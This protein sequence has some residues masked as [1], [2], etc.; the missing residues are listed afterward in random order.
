MTFSVRLTIVVVA[1]AAVWSASLLVGS[2]ASGGALFTTTTTLCDFRGPD[3]CADWLSVHASTSA[4]AAGGGATT[5]FTLGADDALS[6]ANATDFTATARNQLELEWQSTFAALVVRVRNPRVIRPR[7]ITSFGPFTAEHACLSATSTFPSAV[8]CA[9]SWQTGGLLNPSGSTGVPY[10]GYGLVAHEDDEIVC[11]DAEPG[12]DVAFDLNVVP[13]ASNVT[14]VGQPPSVSESVRFSRNSDLVFRFASGGEVPITLEF[15]VINVVKQRHEQT[16][17]Q[18][19]SVCWRASAL[20]APTKDAATGFRV[21][22][23]VLESTG[24]TGLQRNDGAFRAGFTCPLSSAAAS[25]IG[26]GSSPLD[27]HSAETP[28]GLFTPASGCEALGSSSSVPA[29]YESSRTADP[30]SA[31]FFRC[32]TH[33]DIQ[34]MTSVRD[35]TGALL[36]RRYPQPRVVSTALVATPEGIVLSIDVANANEIGGEIAL[37]PARSGDKLCTSD[38]WGLV[39]HTPITQVAVVG[40]Y[41]TARLHFELRAPSLYYAATT[42][43]CT[44]ELRVFGRV[45]GIAHEFT[46]SIAAVEPPPPPAPPA[47]APSTP[48]DPDSPP[49]GGSG[50]ECEGTAEG[51]TTA[52]CAGLYGTSQPPRTFYDT[53]ARAC[54]PATSCAPAER[55]DAE[56]NACA[57]LNVAVPP[58]SVPAQP[59]AS[60]SSAPGGGLPAFP[61][62]GIDCR[63]GRPTNTSACECD[64]G[65]ESNAAATS[66]DPLASQDTTTSTVLVLCNSS[67][68]AAQTPGAGDNGDT[69]GIPLTGVVAGAGALIIQALV[70]LGLVG[71]ALV[72][73]CCACCC[74]RCKGSDDEHQD[75]RRNYN[76]NN[77]NS[78]S[79][80]PPR[81]AVEV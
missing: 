13:T 1:V 55:Y 45:I 2:S 27:A 50:A 18:F 60:T 78:S 25:D 61:T 63:H 64:A 39:A 6:D 56:T 30:P 28:A 4:L 68:L 41:A 57:P 53:A 14:V 77:D 54:I 65:Y 24:W 35:A 43:D 44:V 23:S 49:D 21:L 3:A 81:P 42:L 38:E 67:V 80:N 11:V 79:A 22:R 76:N 66:F 71:L 69:A 17:F 7:R 46:L 10:V 74:R 48:N 34:T 8:C 31:L 59:D 33:A 58:T 5:R 73:L 52:Q 15:T 47:T 51:C 16:D 40:P 32:A 12:T 75:K 29:R 20:D 72:L 9:E 19:Q 70:G 37:H 62:P 36:V 26:V